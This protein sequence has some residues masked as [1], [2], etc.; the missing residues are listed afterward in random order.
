MVDHTRRRSL[1]VLA[2]VAVLGAVTSLGASET[3][4]DSL[5]PIAFDLSRPTI[6]A[7][8]GTVTYDS[9]TGAFTVQATGLFFLSNNLPDVVPIDDGVAT[10]SLMVDSSGHLEGPGSLAVTGSID[11]DQDGI[12]DVTGDLLTGTVDAFGASPAGPAPWAFNGLFDF[13]GGSLTQ[14][15]IALSGG[16]NFSD[17][18]SLGDR[19]GFDVVV[20]QLVGGILGDFAA[21]FQGNTDKGPVAGVVVP[22]PSTIR[23]VLIALAAIAGR[24]GIARRGL[25]ARRPTTK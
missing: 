14:P 19:G 15:P 1:W 3:R 4:A 12:E 2:R 10:I 20:E 7:T 16:G 5:L 17:L 9:S 25:S 13:T 21:D 11:F 22:E 8:D 23:L 18:F 6:N 24:G